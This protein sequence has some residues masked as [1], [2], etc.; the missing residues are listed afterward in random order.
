[1]V[2]LLEADKQNVIQ[3]LNSDYQKPWFGKK[4]SGKCCD[5]PDMTYE[6]VALRLTDLHWYNGT[7]Q[8][9]PK[10]RWLDVSFRERVFDWLRLSEE[11]FCCSSKQ[12][13]M[14]E[15][16]Q[17]EKTPLDFLNSFFDTYPA[18]REQLLLAADVD[19][20]LANTCGVPTRKPINFIPGIS[21][22]F[23]RYFKTDSLWYSEIVEAVPGFEAERSF[24]I[25]GPVA[26]KYNK[27]KNE[28]VKEVLDGI[29]DG[30]CEILAKSPQDTQELQEL[31]DIS[32]VS[33][34]FDLQQ[35]LNNHG[36]SCKVL[37]DECELTLGEVV[38]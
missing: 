6:E 19:Y 37:N 3:A 23:K 2:K 8:G 17:L 4:R 5:V 26:T 16:A 7:M 22:M 35:M 10:P 27:I 11:R 32:D 25:C 15:A 36:A 12:A 20:F 34:A 21:P 30:M 9:Q 29:N 33:S 14:V 13:V 24:I 38:P 31:P 1:M 18:A 28:T